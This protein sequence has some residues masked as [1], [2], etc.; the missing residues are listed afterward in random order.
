MDRLN[1]ENILNYVLEHWKLEDF[2]EDFLDSVLT[3]LAEKD[4]KEAN[5]VLN[6]FLS[7]E[8]ENLL[9][10]IPDKDIESYAEWYL[11]MVDEDDV[12]DV[13]I[14]EFSDS[15]IEEAYFERFGSVIPARTDIIL[16]SQLEELTEKFLNL[17]FSEREE[18]LKQLR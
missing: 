17:S 5:S 18:L 16:D 2:E 15:E 3:L 11:N 14:D 8:W 1:K 10:F 9:G 13:D 12:E 4:L 7:E 6:N